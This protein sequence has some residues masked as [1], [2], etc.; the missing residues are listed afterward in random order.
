MQE[1]GEKNL[2]TMKAQTEIMKMKT[3]FVNRF[4]KFMKKKGYGARRSLLKRREDVRSVVAKNILLPNVHAM[5][6][7][8]KKI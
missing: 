8:R 2:V 4:G 1:Q 6:K 5:M 7:R 3:L